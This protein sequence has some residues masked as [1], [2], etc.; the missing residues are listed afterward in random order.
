MSAQNLKIYGVLGFPAQHSLSPLMQNAAFAALKIKAEY[1]IFE[2]RPE[3]LEGFLG[4]LPEQNIYGLNIT[5]PYK[6]KVIPF[7]KSV[8]SEAGLIG[9]VNTVRVSAKGL[10]GF[11]T[12][13]EGFLRH[14]SEDLKFNPQGKIIAILGAGGA[15][16]AVT[17]SLSKKRPKIISLYDLDK[18]KL[19]RL[20]SHLKEN[21]QHTEFKTADS[22]AGLDIGVCDLFINATPVGMEEADPCLIE[23]KFIRRGLLVYDLIYN[24]KETN[25]LKIAKEKGARTAN[26]LGMLLY[27]GARS[28]ELWIGI[29]APLE[30]MRGALAK[31]A[32]KL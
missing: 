20:I 29:K 14:L 13:A 4:S 3:E 21:F 18:A 23:G 11:N 28:F 1:R 26:G 9:A 6:E 10:E 2:K 8:S 17:V 30:V 24:P 16:R 25:L 27:Q 31:G 7:L 5:V 22:I 19:A 12:D 32:D 15:A